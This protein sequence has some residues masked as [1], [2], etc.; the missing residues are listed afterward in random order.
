[1]RPPADGSAPERDIADLDDVALVVR[2]FY[3]AAIPDPL[4]G[5]LF[6]AGGIEWDVHIPLITSFWARELLDVPGYDG[7]LA[8]AHGPV[9]AEPTFGPAALARWVELFRETVD[10]D[11][12]G[13]VAE[14]A[15]ERAAQVARVLGTLAARGQ[16]SSSFTATTS[17]TTMITAR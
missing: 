6:R 17:P 7:N 3:Q 14:R 8:R 11:F 2:R 16:S 13:P 1:V 12:A 4:L 15:K 10:E 9:M 5:H